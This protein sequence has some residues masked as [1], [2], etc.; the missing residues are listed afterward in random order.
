MQKSDMEAA[1][2]D[3][4]LHFALHIRQIFQ[5]LRVEYPEKI[6]DRQTYVL[7]CVREGQ[8][9]MK[10]YFDNRSGLLVRLV[11]YSESPLGRNPTQIDYADYRN[12]DGLQVPFRLTI[13]EPG[14]RSTLQIDTVQQNVTID[15]AR[16][17]KP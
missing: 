14:G 5:E 7:F 11:R 15:D 17:A 6:G 10:L 12:V 1:R 16:F 8:P 3:A 13:S 9:P 2:L 4:D